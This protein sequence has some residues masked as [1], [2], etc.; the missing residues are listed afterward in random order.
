MILFVFEGEKTEPKVFD[1]LRKV[2]FPQEESIV[3]CT[4]NTDFHSLYK[5]LSENDW[6]LFYVL[7]ERLQ[8]HNDT[9]LDGYKSSDFGQIYLFF[10]YDFQNSRF[11]VSE[12]NRRLNKMLEFF[13]EET[14][15]GKLFVNYPMVESIRY[16]KKLPDASYDDYVVSREQCKEFKSLASSF[17]FYPDLSFLIVGNT[18][19]VPVEEVMENWKH[20]IRQNVG[21]AYWLCDGEKDDVPRQKSLISQD[22]I[23]SAQVAKYVEPSESVAILN[24]FPLFVFEY[25]K[26]TI[27]NIER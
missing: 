9:R 5:N 18:N 11:D 4:Y 3:V 24:A 2:F 6:D 12:Q 25:L 1:S 8:S 22:K 10:D 14:E 15:N 20:L 26:D 17:S 27:S 19:N 7:K 23:F 13:N 21:K 16:T